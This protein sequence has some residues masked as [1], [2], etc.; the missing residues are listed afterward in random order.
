MASSG[1]VYATGNGR[2]YSGRVTPGDEKNDGPVC[3]SFC[4][5]FH[6]LIGTPRKSEQHE[7]DNLIGRQTEGYPDGQAENDL[8]IPG[9][10]S[11]T[12]LPGA[13]DPFRSNAKEK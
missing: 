1:Q 13:A 11:N 8:L 5:P 9:I 12:Q 6:R 7:G 4:L 10:R 2:L 3:F